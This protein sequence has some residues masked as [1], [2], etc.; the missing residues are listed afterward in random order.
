MGQVHY[1]DT[2]PGE[3]RSRIESNPD[4]RTFIEPTAVTRWGIWPNHEEGPFSDPNVRKALMLAYPFEEALVVIAGSRDLYVA[5]GTL[6]LCGNARWGGIR[7]PGDELYYGARDL[8]TAQGLV[9]DAGVAGEKIVLLSVKGNNQTE[10]P[11]LITKN[12]LED[13]GFEVD[14]RA[15]DRA[16]YSEQ[17]SDP[18]VMDLFHTGG[19]MSWGGISPL[20]NSSIS[21]DTYWNRYKDEGGEFTAKLEEFA[22]SGPDRQ[23]ELVRELQVIFFEDLQYIPI[24]E[25]FPVRAM[26]KELQ[27]VTE[28]LMFSNGANF[29]N[30][31]LDN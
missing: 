6:V 22:R 12:V 2:I 5:C 8:A 27:G 17:R 3:Q 13:L 19:G 4:L 25:T 11:A 29:M 10:G 18:A 9:Q 1:I 7:T 26:R 31:W 28:T 20:L 21:K 14:F 30:A 23:D 24:G 15:V 16:T